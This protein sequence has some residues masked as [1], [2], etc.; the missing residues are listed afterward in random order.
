MHKSFLRIT[1]STVSIV[2]GSIMIAS[3]VVAALLMLGTPAVPASAAPGA[4]TFIAVINGGQENPPTTSNS[5]GNAHLIFDK[6]TDMLCYSIS[7]SALA[8]AE[9]AAHFHSPAVAGVNA[10]VLFGITPAVSPLGSPKTGCVGPL[11]NQQHRDLEKGLFY[12]NVHST[13]IPTGEIRG[14]VL[15]I[16]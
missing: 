11:S 3:L 10:S 13:G 15:W 1:K 7:Y 16:R 14:Q 6:T 8:S 9:T 5:F 4:V 12:I 2:I